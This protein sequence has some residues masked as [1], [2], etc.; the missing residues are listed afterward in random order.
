V[1]LPTFQGEN[2]RAWILEC[3][4]IFSLVGITEDQRVKWGLA[5]V[6]GQAKTWLSSSGINLQQLSWSRLCQVLI[7][8][9][10]DNLSLDPMDQLQHLK[11]TASVDNYINAYETW[12]TLM[13]RGRSYLPQDFFID[14]FV[15]GLKDNIKHTVQ[16]QKPDS[17]L[18][19]YWYARQYEKS[20]LSSNRK[21]MPG[22]NAAPLPARNLP[23][24]DNRNREVNVR[25]REPRKCWYC[26]ENWTMGHKCQ[27]MQRAI[28]A[29][30]MQG[31]SEDDSDGDMIQEEAAPPD[32]KEQQAANQEVQHQ[33]VDNL[34][35]IS[36][37][38]YTGSPSASTISLLL[39]MKGAEA[40]A[41]ADTGSTNTFLDHSFALKHNIP[42]KPAPRRTVTVAGGGI[43]TSDAVALNQ[44]FRINNTLFHADFRIL[45][46]QGAD[47]ILGVNWFKLHNPVTFDFIGRTLT[48]DN[49]GIQQ[50]FSD[51]LVPNKNLLI[52]AKECSKILEQGATGY[53]LIPPKDTDNS[54]TEL[55]AELAL[56][57]QEFEDI[58][59]SPNGLP[60]HRAAD[61]SIP[62]IAGATPPN[63]RPYRMSHGQR[64]PL[65]QSSS[66][67]CKMKKFN[68]APVLSLHL[69][70]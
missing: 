14:R 1:E 50:T 22:N 24:R 61:H 19:A 9:F 46:L 32:I 21:H 65:K 43:L 54:T 4:D 23:N 57:L 29:L 41:L 34:M 16:C 10:P 35:H 37:A 38:A 64:T 42:T 55:P 44:P 28:N 15:S 13:K 5:H 47:I 30:Q 60:P 8:R 6:R 11:Q 63:I 70:S 7:D 20:Y 26:P 56:I 59:S 33:P 2:P 18:S 36:A 12:M 67:C 69:S 53:I 62:L 17:L 3:E 25:Q 39:Q 31:N 58:F 51:H 40:V 49:K 48:L 52:T 66:K 45:K 27:P 68:P